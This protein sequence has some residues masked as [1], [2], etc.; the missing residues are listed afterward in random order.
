MMLDLQ[1]GRVASAVERMAALE[2]AGADAATLGALYVDAFIRLVNDGDFALARQMAEGEG[3]E[4]RLPHCT[5]PARQDALVALLLQELQPG[6]NAAR[7]PDRVT[8]LRPTQISAAQLRELTL[9]AFTT[10][11]NQQEFGAARAL[12]APVEPELLAL[13]PPF[14]PAGRDALFAAGALY[15]ED[16]QEW[17]RGASCFGRLRDA[18]AK[19]APPGAAPEPLFWPA[20]RGEVV[21]LHRLER[22]EEATLLLREFIGAYPDAPE[23]LQQQIEPHE[24]L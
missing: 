16:E 21:A 13:R 8:A 10:L 2:Q 1:R 14:D 17:R 20:L 15:L 11:V 22:Y 5:A 4:Q 19:S 18:L 24:T 3:V 7:V 12:L 9:I 6:G 23:D